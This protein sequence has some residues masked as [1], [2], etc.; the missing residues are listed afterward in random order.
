LTTIFFFE[1]SP[2]FFII[3]ASLNA[4]R[5][6]SS[7]ILVKDSY[8]YIWCLALGICAYYITI[9]R[10]R[11]DA[12]DSFIILLK[13]TVMARK[14]EVNFARAS[15]NTFNVLIDWDRYHSWVCILLFILWCCSNLVYH[16]EFSE[17]CFSI[18]IHP[19][20]H[21]V[22]VGFAQRLRFMNVLIDDI[23]TFC[24]FE[25][26]NCSE[27]CLNNAFSCFCLVILF[28]N[29]NYIMNTNYCLQV[30]FMNQN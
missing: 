30:I 4:R 22:L 15:R 11:V 24:E 12:I 14:T 1:I 20:G 2:S 27:V 10:L 26:R 13:M 9:V 16:K 17:E 8:S 6:L 19:S 28:M 18:A 3:F 29:R 23:K 7:T 25:I 21:H 5:H